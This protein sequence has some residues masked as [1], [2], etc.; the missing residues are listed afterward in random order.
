M[1]FV[2]LP[3]YTFVTFRNYKLKFHTSKKLDKSSQK[4]KLFSKAKKRST[5]NIK[6]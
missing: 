3:K 1:V 4:K 2:I 5:Q 6:F